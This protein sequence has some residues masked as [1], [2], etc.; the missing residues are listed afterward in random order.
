[1]IYIFH[2]VFCFTAYS[3]LQ[4]A[5]SRDL[6]A[7]AAKLAESIADAEA[8][9]A[10]AAAASAR[11]VKRMEAKLAAAEELAVQVRVM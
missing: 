4:S 3:T 5:H 2:S 10:D 9:A 8:A 6:S 11:A 1:M 7:A